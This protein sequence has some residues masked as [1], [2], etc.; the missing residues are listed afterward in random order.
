MLNARRFTVGLALPATPLLTTPAALTRLATAA[1]DLGFDALFTHDH[2]LPPASRPDLAHQLDAPTLLAWLA[3][4]TTRIALG[5]SVLV[6]PY[7]RPEELAKTAG[8][9]DWL[10]D[11]RLVLGVG[12]GWLEEEFR[13]LGVPLGQR[14]AR[15]DEALA[16]L[17]RLWGRT[18]TSFGGR[19]SHFEDVVSRPSGAPMR[20]DGPPI[21]VGGNSPAAR[22]RAA[23]LGD[24]WHPLNLAAADEL[25]AA[26]V[27]YRQ[28]RRMAAGD[29]GVVI[30]RHFPGAP[31]ARPGGRPP[32]TGNATQIAGDVAR[33]AEAGADGL[34]LSWDD[35]DIDGTLRRWEA[36]AT[37]T[38]GALT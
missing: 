38:I 30:A 33:H 2:I 28:E 19:W 25:P 15:T 7:R 3:A 14:G 16:V 37:A 29:E 18:P 13:A 21:L 31:H 34:V 8:T 17:R 22:R 26:I 24:G 36:F 4:A 12:A 20:P 5:T 27:A 35:A 23:L 6:L 9:I 1:E 32:F 10:S 11:G